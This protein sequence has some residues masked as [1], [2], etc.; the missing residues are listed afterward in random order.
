MPRRNRSNPLALA[1][2]V[3]LYEK[4]MHP[5]EI[6]QTL[7]LRAKHESVRLNYGS[8]YAVVE[9]LERKNLIVARETV[10]EGNRPPRTIYEIT[11]DGSREMVDWLTDM[12]GVPAKEYPQ[13]LAGL[14]FIAALTPDDA[15]AALQLRANTLELHLAQIRATVVA[16]REAGL[17]RLFMLET[18][19]EE[20]LIAAE[21]HFVSGLIKDMTS[22][23]LDGL[24]LWKSFHAD[25]MNP[26]EGVV[27]TIDPT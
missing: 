2:L 19:F 3:S 21:L 6:A 4:P 26:L 7:R 5:Y 15:L 13:F 10:R 8:L 18:E 27:F 24:D 23:D 9:A 16:S 22:A 12:I 17:P 14:S 25:G 20:Q 11:E 1:V